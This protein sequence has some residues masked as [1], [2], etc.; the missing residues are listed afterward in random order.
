M[1]FDSRYGIGVCQTDVCLVSSAQTV[2]SLVKQLA[3]VT[4]GS[5]YIDFLKTSM[6]IIF[7]RFKSSLLTA[8]LDLA[9]RLRRFSETLRQQRRALQG[10]KRKQDL[11]PITL[12]ISRNVY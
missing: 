9:G 5:R 4:G 12:L 2:Q 6:A 11:T 10:R 3:F 7:N 1:I 8:R